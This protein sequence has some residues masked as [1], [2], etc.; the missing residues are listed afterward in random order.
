MPFSE[1]A[2]MSGHFVSS[3]VSILLVDE[4]MNFSFHIT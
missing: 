2:F 4:G 1:N 3:L